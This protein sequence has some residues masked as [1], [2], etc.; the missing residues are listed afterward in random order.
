MVQMGSASGPL[1]VRVAT[2]DGN[3]TGEFYSCIYTD[4]KC[5]MFMLHCLGTTRKLFI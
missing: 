3:A 1:L 2:S 4:G 5:G